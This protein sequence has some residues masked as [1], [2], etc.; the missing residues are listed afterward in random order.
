MC[1]RQVPFELFIR[2]RDRIAP[3]GRLAAT[4]DITTSR[5]E[6]FMRVRTSG[7]ADLVLKGGP[8]RLS[9]HLGEGI[10]E[11]R[12]PYETAG[13]EAEIGYEI[14][15]EWDGT[16][17][18]VLAL[19]ARPLELLGESVVEDASASPRLGFARVTSSVPGRLILALPYHPYWTASIDGREAEV[20]RGPANTVAVSIPAR[21]G[22]VNVRV[23]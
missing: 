21:G 3:Y 15:P 13:G 14:N 16:T 20:T 6:V 9:V 2:G 11:V 18:D 22:L 23:Q 7:R 19:E 10:T 12:V 4:A 17:I 1:P 5:L 8:R